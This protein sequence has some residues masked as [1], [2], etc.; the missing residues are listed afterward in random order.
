MPVTHYLITDATAAEVEEKTG[1]RGHP[2]PLGVLVEA[3]PDPF[4]EGLRMN[5]DLELIKRTLNP[6]PPRLCGC[7]VVH[8]PPCRFAYMV[9]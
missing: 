4:I 1:L 6:P 2:T 5:G 7:N 3:P 9:T 8:M